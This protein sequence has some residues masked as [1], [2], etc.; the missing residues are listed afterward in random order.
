[1]SSFDP[2]EE[3]PITPC[4]VCLKWLLLLP[5][6]CDSEDEIREIPGRW[7]FHCSCAD[8]ADPPQT[9]LRF[10]LPP[11]ATLWGR[12]GNPVLSAW[13]SRGKCVQIWS[14]LSIMSRWKRADQITNLELITK[15][16]AAL[17]LIH[18][19]LSCAVIPAAICP[20]FSGDS[21]LFSRAP[22]GMFY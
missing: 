2:W 10:F 20:S 18:S 22:H 12:A 9:T 6:L 11:S 4:K 8:S 3:H 15:V 17:C 1:M 21:V 13:A 16:V 14:P 7:D 5:S 19:A